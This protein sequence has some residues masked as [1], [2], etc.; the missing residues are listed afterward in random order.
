MVPENESYDE[1]V[2]YNELPKIGAT[3]KIKGQETVQSE[4][5]SIQGPRRL[6]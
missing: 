2:G 5:P 6:D 3:P 1:K 4:S